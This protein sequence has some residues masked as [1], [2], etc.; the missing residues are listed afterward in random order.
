MESII[1]LCEASMSAGT[2]VTLCVGN[3]QIPLVVTRIEGHEYVQGRSMDYNNIVVSLPA[4]TA[5]M[6]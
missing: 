2:G 4:V 5:A 1:K 6:A 3:H